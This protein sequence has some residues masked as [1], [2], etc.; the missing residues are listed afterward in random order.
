MSSLPY[1]PAQ[2]FIRAPQRSMVK[3]FASMQPSIPENPAP[4]EIVKP[5]YMF[6]N[7]KT[8]LNEIIMFDMDNTLTPASDL[9]EDQMISYLLKLR[10]KGY[11]LGIVT[12]ASQGKLFNQIP[13]E[14]RFLFDFLFSE[15]GLVEYRVI[16]DGGIQKAS[17]LIDFLG[18]Q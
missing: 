16:G 10:S 9:I 3:L 13:Q 12:G 14:I 4:K 2:P 5:L 1:R 15:N 7:P 18:E 6:S 17:R 11:R 8:D